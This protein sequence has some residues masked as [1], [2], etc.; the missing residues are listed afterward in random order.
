MADPTVPLVTAEQAREAMT[1]EHLAQMRLDYGP[2]LGDGSDN[3]HEDSDVVAL[4]DCY[5]ALHARL[6]EHERMA[7]L[8]G[9]GCV[10]AVAYKELADRLAAVR[11]MASA[12]RVYVLSTDDVLDV[13]DD[14]P[15]TEGLSAL[16][17]DVD[18]YRAALDAE[19]NQ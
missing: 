5:V 17:V 15:N 1:P 8:T 13:L 4:V 18:A 2:S 19:G 16:G 9:D 7:G 11:A 14:R 12:P 6:A 3:P 10:P